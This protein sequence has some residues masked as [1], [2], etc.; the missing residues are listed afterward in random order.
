[1]LLDANLHAHLADIHDIQ[2]I[3]SNL[4]RICPRTVQRH[5]PGLRLHEFGQQPLISLSRIANGLRFRGSWSPEFV[6]SE[7][8]GQRTSRRYQ[9]PSARHPSKPHAL[10]PGIS[11]QQGTLAS[12]FKTNKILGSSYFHGYMGKMGTILRSWYR[13]S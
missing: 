5:S 1:M 12:V 6:S 10:Y 9:T 3:L 2:P 7:S 11:T 4:W 13:Q 8:I